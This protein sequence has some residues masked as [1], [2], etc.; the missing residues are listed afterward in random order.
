[1]RCAA[2]DQD[3]LRTY[4]RL[5]R[6]SNDL[7]AG[8]RPAALTTLRDLAA[9]TNGLT[10]PE[11]WRMAGN[12]A[13]LLLR[14]GDVEG[15]AALLTPILADVRKAGYGLVLAQAEAGLAEIEAARGHWDASRTHAAAARRAIPADIWVVTSRLDHVDIADALARGDRNTA[16]TMLARSDAEAHRYND[17]I[18]QLELHGLMAPTARLPDGCDATARKA[19]LARSGMRGASLDWLFDPLAARNPLWHTASAN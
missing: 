18:A 15:A 14:A 17:A 10:G 12:I 2:P 6:A 8:D 11:R 1:M 13:P 16:E 4:A 3:A 19:L 9:R 7:L 5:G